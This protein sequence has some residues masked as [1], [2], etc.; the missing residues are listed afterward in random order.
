MKYKNFFCDD[1]YKTTD[2]KI[3]MLINNLIKTFREE[4]IRKF[5]P[6]WR[7][8][9]GDTQVF[10]FKLEKKLLSKYG[11]KRENIITVRLQ[12]EQLDVEVLNSTIVME[13]NFIIP[14]MPQIAVL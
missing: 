5:Y 13:K 11:K 8:N 2:D 12:M 9:E 1:K 14:Q 4:C 3:K 6:K 7:G 10:V